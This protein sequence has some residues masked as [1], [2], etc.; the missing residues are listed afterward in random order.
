MAP[1]MDSI[2]RTILATGAAA[3][4]MAA[5]PRVFAQQSAQGGAAERFYEKG[6]VRIRYEEAGSGFPLLLIAGGGLNSTLAGLANPFNSIEEVK[7]EYRCVA[8]DLR[9]ANPG[10]SSGPLEIDRAW[11]SHTDDQL[12][13]MDHLGINKF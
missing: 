12:A 5:A 8:A 7:G 4:A 1:I 11:D 10:Q 3:T 2:R 13:V 9:N 6:S